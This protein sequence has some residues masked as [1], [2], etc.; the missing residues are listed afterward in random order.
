MSFSDSINQSSFLFAQSPSVRQSISRYAPRESS[1][2]LNSTFEQN[3]MSTTFNAF[4]STL[5]ASNTTLSNTF[6]ATPRSNLS[7]ADATITPSQDST[8][9]ET[10]HHFVQSSPDQSWTSLCHQFLDALEKHADPSEVFDLAAESEDICSDHLRILERL[11]KQRAG[12]SSSVPSDF[13]SM[14]RYERNSW[15][16]ARSLY[17]DRLTSANAPIPLCDESEVLT[18][19]EVVD[20]LYACKSIIREMQLVVDWCEQNYHEDIQ[21]IEANDKIEFYSEGPHY[22][23]HTLHKA[24]KSKVAVSSSTEMCLQMDPDASYRSG[25]EINQQDKEDEVRVMRFIFRNV[26]AGKLDVGR[27]TAQKLGYHWLAAGLHGWMLHQDFNLKEPRSEGGCEGNPRRDLWKYACWCAS[28]TPTMSLMEKAIFGLLSAN[29]SAVLPACSTWEDKIWAHFRCSI[30][31]QIEE[32][33]RTTRAPKPVS[34]RPTGQLANSQRFSVDLPEQYWTNMRSSAEI[35][36]D[37]SCSL[38]DHTWNREEKFHFLIQVYLILNDVDGLLSTIHDYISDK[39][40][41]SSLMSNKLRPQLLRFSAHLV[42]FLKNADQIVTDTQMQYYSSILEA[43]INYL[44]E[45]KFISLV[46]PYVAQMPSEM[47]V[48]CYSQLLKDITDKS[49]RLKCLQL[50][51]DHNLNVEDITRSVVETMKVSTE[52]DSVD[53]S[54]RANT[55]FSIDGINSEPITDADQKLI[56]ALE[57]LSVGNTQYI[58]LLRQ[59]NSLIRRFILS[60][61]LLAAR[62]VFNF[63]PRELV[64]AVQTTWKKK[65]GSIELSPELK[66]QTKQHL[67]WDLFFRALEFFQD[68]AKLYQNKPTKPVKPAAKK[69]CDRIAYEASEHQY[70]ADLSSWQASLSQQAQMVATKIHDVLTFPD[71]GWLKESEITNVSRKESEISQAQELATIRRRFVPQLAFLLHNILH[72]SACYSYAIRVSEIVASDLHGLHEEFTDEQMR[73]FV[74]KMR[75]SS[76]AAMNEN[77]DS[78]GYATVTDDS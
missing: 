22:W 73:L 43:Y 12:N 21:D 54:A 46:A 75:E 34:A 49:E 16:L 18:D 36:Q 63:T 70:L 38:N 39:E 9:V 14:I 47:Q 78:L 41:I 59:S 58:E 33:L 25:K 24:S 6:L 2:C 71:S 37:I 15:R 42:L 23:E 13:L 27:E 45:K 68:W 30:D 29:L 3:T 4:E 8:F 65:T 19:R 76:I 40:S 35:L 31:A 51:R 11:K 1:L 66:N 50:A 28:S 67:C 5:N 62:Q 44:I 7:R 52:V 64:S 17:S 26:R 57:W 32:E 69:F 53:S 56:R 61:K 77:L 48:Y 60:G 10:T 55:D 74:K 20:Q 72:V